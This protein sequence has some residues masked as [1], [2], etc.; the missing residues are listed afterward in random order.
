MGHLHHQ[1][2]QLAAVS[3]SRKS[4]R[5][6]TRDLGLF[7][8][9]TC[10]QSTSTGGVYRIFMLESK[11]RKPRNSI[12]FKSCSWLTAHPSDE[13]KYG[14]VSSVLHQCL[15]HEPWVSP[16]LKPGSETNRRATLLQLRLWPPQIYFPSLMGTTYF[17]AQKCRKL[18]LKPLCK[19]PDI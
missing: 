19:G 13:L 3:A 5:S 10:P 1:R 11:R 18:P 6:R 4:H 2:R 8:F 14:C 9:S 15:R 12:S 16:C 17:C 7:V